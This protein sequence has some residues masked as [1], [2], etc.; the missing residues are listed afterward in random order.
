MSDR[1]MKAAVRELNLVEAAAIVERGR[2]APLAAEE[3]DKLEATVQTLSLLTEKINQKSASIARL[4][5]LIFGAKTEKTKEVLGA[6]DAASAEARADTS[7]NGAATPADTGIDSAATPADAGKRADKGGEEKKREGHGRNGA[8]LPFNRLEKPR[9]SM[10]IPLP[11]ATQWD[12]VHA[13]ARDLLSAWHELTREAAQ[14]EVLH[15]DDTRMKVLELTAV[16][17]ARRRRRTRGRTATAPAPS[18]PASFRGGRTHRSR[19]SSRA[20]STPGRTSKMSSSSERPPCRPRS[21][22]ATRSTRTPPVT[23]R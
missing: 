6:A 4:R 23:S 11:A 19:S 10:G 13:G 14:G 8:G 1:G 15:N 2:V 7:I 9:Q 5:Q 17:R 20:Y 18:P 3:W 12:L 16:A 21:R 22:C